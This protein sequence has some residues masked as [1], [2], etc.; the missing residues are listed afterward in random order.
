MSLHARSHM[1]MPF[2]SLTSH[3]ARSVDYVRLQ[4]THD[5]STLLRECS[6]SERPTLGKGSL[7]EV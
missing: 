5:G 1:L 7:G 4:T 3:Q 6:R 2:C